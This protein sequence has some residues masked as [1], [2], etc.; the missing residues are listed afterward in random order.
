MWL[1][2]MACAPE[3]EE[4]L[5]Q[6]VP[7]EAGFEQRIVQGWVCEGEERDAGTY[8]GL[9]GDERYRVQVSLPLG[10]ATLPDDA[11]A[12]FRVYVGAHLIVDDGEDPCDELVV[13]MGDEQRLDHAYAAVAGHAWLVQDGE[14]LGL[15]VEGLV[16]REAPDLLEEDRPG[17]ELPEV[18]LDSAS[19]PSFRVW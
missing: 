3:A 12:Y 13:M 11:D 17:P 18:L 1:W 15:Q 8:Y 9:D 5:E 10:E 14:Q 4:E 19:F 16:L 7:L 6:P 2:W